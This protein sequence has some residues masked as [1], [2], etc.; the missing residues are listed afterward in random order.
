MTDVDVEDLIDDLVRAM[1]RLYLE[2][3]STAQYAL[4]RNALAD[5]SAELERLNRG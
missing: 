2:G 1:N 4:A 5:L 3:P